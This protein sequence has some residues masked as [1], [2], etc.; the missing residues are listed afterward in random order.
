MAEVGRVGGTDIDDEKVGEWAE[1]SEG[2]GI[3][4]GGFSF[5]GFGL[6]YGFRYILLWVFCTHVVFSIIGFLGSVI[7][8]V[9]YNS[10]VGAKGGML[11]DFEDVKSAYEQLPPPPPD[12]K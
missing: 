3:V 9:L 1:Q 5:A 6:R 11:L 7:G 12:F 2:S 4:F 10:L 8:G